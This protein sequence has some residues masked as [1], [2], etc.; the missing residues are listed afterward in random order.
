[1]EKD[2]L[3]TASPTPATTI[4]EMIWNAMYS[5]VC[6]KENAAHLGRLLSSY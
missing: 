1:M 2:G 4:R 6:E 5:L 3:A